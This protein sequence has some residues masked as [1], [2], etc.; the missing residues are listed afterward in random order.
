MIKQVIRVFGNGNPWSR[1]E[2][3]ADYRGKDL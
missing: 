3:E 1:G 2:I